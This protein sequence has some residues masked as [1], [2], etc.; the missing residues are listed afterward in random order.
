MLFGRDADQ[1]NRAT[2]PI[3][4]GKILQRGE[5]ELM[6]KSVVWNDVLA[7]LV[8]HL[9]VWNP[10]FKCLLVLDVLW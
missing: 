8:E 10:E 3:R 1:W 5:G 2:F 6:G 4:E 9:S 7:R